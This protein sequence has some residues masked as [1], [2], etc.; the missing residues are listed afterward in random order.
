MEATNTSV[1]LRPSTKAQ[2]NALRSWTLA[3][4]LKRG[5][6]VTSASVDDTVLELIR[7]SGSADREL[8]SYLPKKGAQASSASSPAKKGARRAAPQ[9][10]A[11]ASS[12]P[13]KGA[14]APP[15]ARPARP[16]AAPPAAVRVALPAPAGH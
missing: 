11:R 16:A 14:Q 1:A 3:R 8:T 4:A 6:H 13:G 7:A 10:G 15:A 12:P 5:D 9:K 2:L